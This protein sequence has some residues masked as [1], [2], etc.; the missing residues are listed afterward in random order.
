MIGFQAISHLTL[1]TAYQAD[2]NTPIGHDGKSSRYLV[3]EESFRPVQGSGT[4]RVKY[5]PE[6]RAEMTVGVVRYA[7]YSD[8]G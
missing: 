1:D 8:R 5:I 7:G 4:D 6:P 2:Y 3:P